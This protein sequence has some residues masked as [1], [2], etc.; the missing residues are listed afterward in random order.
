MNLSKD[1]KLTL[2]KA[3]QATGTSAVPSDAVDMQG[4]DAVWFF[5]SLASFAA[6]NFATV[7]QSSDSGAA[8]DWTDVAGTKVAPTVNG[9]SF[10]VEV[11]KPEK[12]Y[13]RVNLTR[14]TTTI[15]GDVYALQSGSRKGPTTQGATVEHETHVSPIEGTA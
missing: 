12:R 3:G 1:C 13:V 4:F 2:V 6:G 10:S 5:G 14:G 11:V 7:Q 9:N 8:D 15:T